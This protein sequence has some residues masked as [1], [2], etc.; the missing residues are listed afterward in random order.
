[1]NEQQI[2]QLMQEQLQPAFE[3]LVDLTTKSFKTM[4]DQLKANPEFEKNPK[5]LE[6]I[7][8]DIFKQQAAVLEKSFKE[9]MPKDFEKQF[10]EQL[11]ARR[12]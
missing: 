9:E 1:M 4:Y 7:L 8:E 11:N 2:R 6:K 3:A 10:K 5:A 12:S